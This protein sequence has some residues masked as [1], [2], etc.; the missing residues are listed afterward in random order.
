M[1]IQLVYRGY[2]SN[3]ASLPLHKYRKPH[4]L[5]WRYQ[6]PGEIYEEIRSLPVGYQS[7]RAINWRYARK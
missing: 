7:P 6:V 4:V 1:S 5:N 2:V 3:D